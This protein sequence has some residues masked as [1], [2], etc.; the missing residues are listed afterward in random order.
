MNSVRH[1]WQVG[2]LAA[3]LAAGFWSTAAQAAAWT[4]IESDVETAEPPPAASADVGKGHALQRRARLTADKRPPL[5]SSRAHLRVD[6]DA[7]PLTKAAANC[8][9]ARF[10]D[11]DGA[12]LVALVR[13]STTDCINTLFSLQGAAAA[14]VFAESR[15]V[16]V[17]NAL[18]NDAVAYAGNNNGGILQLILFLRAGYFVE[19]YDDAVPDYGAAM[20]NAIRPALDAFVA[21]TRFYAVDNAHG[22]VLSEF[23]T[24]IDSSGENTRHLPTVKGLLD[25]YGASHHDKPNMQAAVNSAFTVLFRGHYDD[26][27]RQR[28]ESDPSILDSLYSFVDRNRSADVGTGREYLLRNAA[29]EL[30]RFL[31][32]SGR[33]RD[34]ARPKVKALLERFA[35]GSPGT[36]IYIGLAEMAD[37]YD[38]ANCAYYGVCDFLA[39]LE[40]YALPPA[41]ARDC[42]PTLRVRSQALTAAQLQEVCTITAGM[43]TY[44]HD[45]ARTNRTP[46][47]NDLNAR[48]EMVIFHSSDD[49]EAYSGTLFGNDVNNGG[50]YLEGDPSQPGNQAR[51]LAYEA[52]WLR[53]SFEVWNL[54]HEYVHYLDG[55]FNWH[56]GFGALPLDAPYSSVW[57]IEGFAEYMSYSYRKQRYDRALTEAANP[58]KFTLA[59]LFDNTYDSGS[60]RVYQWGYLAA[61]YM[62]E[63]RRDRITALYA[64]SRTGNYG[65][66]YRTWLDGERNASNADF[67]SWLTCLTANA[68]DT[69]RCNTPTDPGPTVPEC[70]YAQSGQLGDGCQRSGLRAPTTGHPVYLYMEVPQNS[71]RLTLTMS[72]GTGDA[73]LYQRAGQWPSTTAYDNLAANPG[74]DATVTVFAPT[75]GWHYI[76]LRPKTQSFF[77]VR[78]SA[79]LKASTACTGPADRL[80]NHCHRDGLAAARSVD[81]AYLTAFVPAGTR[82]LVVT[83]E[84]GTGDVDLYVR[85]GA[86]PTDTAFDAAP[87]VAGNR[88]QAVINNPTAGWNYIM[89]KPRTQNFAG[90]RIRAAWE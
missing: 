83:T 34:A 22:A 56:G 77:D 42:S 51:F 55:R 18:R 70:T 17:A 46:V 19:Y 52:E 38:G 67:R 84:G 44:F 30:G 7:P 78:V 80:D 61:R 59:Q 39:K 9:A 32:Y 87:R 81:R 49:Y 11:G 8:E 48:L 27:F 88:E 86:W 10:G 53:P 68:G 28:V 33:I 21:N 57:Y 45:A 63:R 89:L 90:V 79:K 43:E 85:G 6:Y 58:D 40:A 64:V 60:T 20:L 36:S 16:A 29:A 13:S 72:G 2:L 23:V 54:T 62:F 26:T 74:N 73:D 69:T 66:G 75:P 31:Q 4:E 3:G 15:M 35:L 37:W 12:A 71:S 47:A 14:R 65:T 82:K 76:V 25:R 5:S 41:N 1:R 50:I 24:L